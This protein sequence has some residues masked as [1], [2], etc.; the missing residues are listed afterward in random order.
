MLALR[1][2]PALSP[3]R[4]DALLA[5]VRASVACVNRVTADYVHFVDAPD[6]LTADERHTLDSLL[7]CGRP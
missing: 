3:F 4:L 7:A 2:S 5:S 1:G 6:T